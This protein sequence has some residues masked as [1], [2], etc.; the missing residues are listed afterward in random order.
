[1]ARKK[2]VEG[3][4]KVSTNHIRI[5][6]N[7][8]VNVKLTPEEIAGRAIESCKVAQEYEELESQFSLV[9]GEWKK[10]LESVETKLTNLRRAVR[11]GEEFRQVDCERVFDVS[12]GTTWLEFEGKRY[13]ER[14][15][16][17]DELALIQ[18]GNIEDTFGTA[19]EPLPLPN[20]E[21]DAH[22]DV[23]F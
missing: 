1:M 11:S 12:R 10:K 23:G 14:S 18:Q 6:T 8:A 5:S 15:A 19:V 7:D 4:A 22:E 3:P 20:G 9:K 13:L 17:N 2:S 21:F 16:T